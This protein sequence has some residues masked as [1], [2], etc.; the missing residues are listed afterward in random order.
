[1]RIVRG[2]FFAR[3]D[4]LDGPV[5]HLFGDQHRLARVVLLATPA[6]TAAEM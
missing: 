1:L 5:G 2:V 4:E 3:P 6:E